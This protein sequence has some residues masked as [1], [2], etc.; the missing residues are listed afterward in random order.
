MVEIP[1]LSDPEEITFP[2][3]LGKCEAYTTGDLLDV[4]KH[5]GLSG[6]KDAWAKTVRWPGH[7]DI[8][9][10]IVDLHLLE[11]EAISVKGNDVSP[12]DF[13][14][15]LGEKTLQY[16]PGEGDAICQRVEVSGIKDGNRT[17]FIYEFIDL[18][19]PEND[20]SAMARTT[21]FPCSIVAQMIAKGDF[22]DAGVIQKLGG[23]NISQ[24]SS[25]RSYLNEKS[26]LRKVK[27][28]RSVDNARETRL[29]VF[30]NYV[31]FSISQIY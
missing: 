4:V 8:W 9:K 10:K 5:L 2:E 26:I 30:F 18:Y 15:A 28:N 29:A 19:D 1:R 20:L 12:R 3:P 6:V 17:S 16:L 13:F 11:E 23:M 24:R 25:S 7:S 31:Y 27:S 22:K 21:A 14:L